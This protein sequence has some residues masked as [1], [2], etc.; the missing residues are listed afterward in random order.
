M[1]S[2]EDFRKEMTETKPAAISAW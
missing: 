1:L 2:H